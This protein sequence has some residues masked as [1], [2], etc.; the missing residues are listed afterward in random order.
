MIIAHDLRAGAVVVIEDQTYKVLE[1]VL[2]AG[3][4]KAGSMVHAKMRNL[5]SGAVL[6]RRF[7]PDD[8]LHDLD[9]QRVKM[10]YLFS[11]GEAYTFMN[12]ETF[13]QVEVA[14]PILG[15]GARFLKENDAL[16]LEFFEGRPLAVRYPDVVELKVSTTGAGTRGDSTY[17]EAVLENGVELLVPHF[18][19][20]GDRVHVD[21][22]TG[23]YLDRVNDKEGPRK[24]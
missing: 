9:V 22:E 13:D 14:K 7:G 10:Q 1:S 3:G 23:K 19:R 20:E 6:E 11:S 5:S 17:K 4:G 15:P 2:H 21:V 18:I 16:E 24:P 12:P 8:K